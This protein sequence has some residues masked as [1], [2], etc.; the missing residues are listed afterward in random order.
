LKPSNTYLIANKKKATMEAVQVSDI[1]TFTTPSTRAGNDAANKTR[2]TIL[3]QTH[4]I[5]VA[6]FQN[7][8]YGETWTHIISAFKAMFERP[9]QTFS[10]QKLAGRKNNHDFQFTYKH[11]VTN[12]T[13]EVRQVEFK[14]N[15]SRMEE[16]PQFLQLYSSADIME[17]SYSEY[18][19]LHF[20]DQYIAL[21]PNLQTV[22]KP[23]LEEYK[24][25]IHKTKYTC[26][27]L[28]QVMYEREDHQKKEK[29]AIVNQS[30]QQFLELYG[31]NLV[32]DKVN[33]HFIRT[34][35]DKEYLFFKNGVFYLQPSLQQTDLHVI[36]NN[37]LKNGNTI[38]LQSETCVFELLLRWKNHK[39]I[40]NPAWQIKLKAL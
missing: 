7:P 36:S 38:L 33:E 35:T 31:P 21:D 11:P 34:Q 16:V 1:L 23:T 9:G 37:G 20:L 25:M 3:E 5:P 6:Y 28:I 13:I 8:T 27:P 19:Y 15:A 12:D 10:I 30:I 17:Q 39:G 26:H 2:E 14:Y 32:L 22:A 40:L 24:K 18:F 4:N 29:A